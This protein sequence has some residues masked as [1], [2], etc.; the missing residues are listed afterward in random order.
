MAV[1]FFVFVSV[2]SL[3]DKKCGRENTNAPSPMT[4]SPKAMYLKI[5]I[6]V[7]M[8]ISNQSRRR[9]NFPNYDLLYLAAFYMCYLGL[10]APLLPPKYVIG[11]IVIH[12]YLVFLIHGIHLAKCREQGK[13]MQVSVLILDIS[14]ISLKRELLLTL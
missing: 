6:N 14:C 7:E 4:K 5:F 11:I 10:E 2:K 9:E 13:S 1:S 8:N 3:S 12:G